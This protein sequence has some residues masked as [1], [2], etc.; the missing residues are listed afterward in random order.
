MSI[1]EE[2][3]YFMYVKNFDSRTYSIND[4]LEWDRNGQLELNPRFQR[5]NVWSPTARS[6]LMDSIVRG[7]PIPK[8]FIRQKLNPITGKSVREVVDGQQRV[9]TI[10]SFMKDGF[11][12]SRRH[13]PTYGGKVF[14]QLGTVDQD[15]QTAIQN[16]EISV[17][18]LVNMPDEEVL[19][20]FSRLNS[21]AVVL[22]EQE[23]LNAKYFGPFK[24]LADS[25]GRAHFKYWV[26]N[27][28]LTDAQVLRMAEVGLAADL[29][30]AM[31]DGVRSKKQITAYYQLYERDFNH[32]P[33]ELERKF[34]STMGLIREIFPEGLKQSEFRRPHLFYTLFTAAY[35]L[36]F[37]LKE[38]VVV[39]GSL[40]PPFVAR[41]QVALAKVDAIYSAEDKRTLHKDEAQFLEDAQRATTDREVRVRR[42]NFVL[43]L[44]A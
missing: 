8:V 20:V 29:L 2:A 23:R 39:R 21:Y 24:T 12:I 18:L 42:T 16:Y 44:L 41:A 19:D 9:R 6:F 38:C 11:A 33:E 26:E 5:R 7:K 34:S 32:E 35:H 22:N 13:H 28:V 1:R 14:S 37:G 25:L 30:I 31:L 36:R 10:L 43:H 3:G 17:D 4:F 27:Q 40:A 15:I